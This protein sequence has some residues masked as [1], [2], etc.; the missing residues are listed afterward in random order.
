M[1]KFVIRT[2]DGKFVKGGRSIVSP[3]RLVDSLQDARVYNRKQDA[4]KSI[5][6]H[7]NSKYG[8]HVVPVNLVQ[9]IYPTL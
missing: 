8:L 1:A 7:F 9:P 3:L 6:E 5:N 4:T 2:T